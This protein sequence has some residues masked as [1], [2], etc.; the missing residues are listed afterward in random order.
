MR[1]TAFLISIAS[2][3]LTGACHS[4]PPAPTPPPQPTAAEIAMHKH[5]QD[6][7]DA[8][9][10]ATADSLAQARQAELAMRAH[11]DSVEQARV[12][13]ETAARDA[14]ALIAEQN[15]ALRTELGVM[16]HFAVAQSKITDD[17]RAAL[18]RKV[19]ILTANPTV[20]LQITGATDE[21][22]SDQYNQALGKRRA[23]AVRKYLIEKGIDV[24]RL[25]EV[26]GGE[27]SPIDSGNNEAAWSQNRRAEF[28]IVAGDGPLAMN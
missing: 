28:A 18:D 2:I 14:A 11:A 21:R 7:L 10:Q 24:A 1:S 19:A 4:S 25:D 5:V 6:S 8:V 3:A 20:R 26:S 16:V 13:A 9:T 22:G 15:T 17:D 27:K 23:A 12:A